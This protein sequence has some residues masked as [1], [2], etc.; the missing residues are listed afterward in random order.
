M[1]KK[2]TSL[3]IRDMFVG[4]IV[5]AW[6]FLRILLVGAALIGALFALIVGDIWVKAIILVIAFFGI[7]AVSAYGEA[8][9]RRNRR[10]RYRKE[11]EECLQ[12]LEDYKAKLAEIENS[13]EIDPVAA[14][15]IPYFKS[16]IKN[17]E[18][19][20]VDYDKIIKDNGG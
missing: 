6:K 8:K 11:R 5:E 19:E 7:C 3:F 12:D 15:D 13:V 20:I 17:L 2:E 16:C 1:D 4:T 18:K 10:I 9:K 14:Q